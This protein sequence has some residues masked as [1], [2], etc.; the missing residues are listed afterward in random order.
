LEKNITG[1]PGVAVTQ[2]S[3]RSKSY[4]QSTPNRRLSTSFNLRKSIIPSSE[5]QDISADDVPSG[6]KSIESAP[7]FISMHNLIEKMDSLSSLSPTSSQ[8]IK[9]PPRRDST[10]KL[11]ALQAGLSASMPEASRERPR[12]ALWPMSPIDDQS[13]SQNQSSSL[14]YN[15]LQQNQLQ[16]QLNQQQQPSQTHRRILFMAEL[17]ALEYFIV[18]HV[19]V[20]KMQPFVADQY[21]TSEL[22]DMIRNRKTTFWNKLFSSFKSTK[23]PKGIICTCTTIFI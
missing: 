1:Q 21:S 12:D 16:S 3:A 11:S 14:T 9:A 22:L 4:S 20:V 18:R 19:A 2:E 23:K 7:N 10:S 15:Q 17:S 13:A 8:P 5:S 6:T